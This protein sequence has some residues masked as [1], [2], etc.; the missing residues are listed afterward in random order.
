M[1][2]DERKKL[3]VKIVP[4]ELIDPNPLQPRSNLGDLGELIDSIKEKGVLEPIIVR[5][6]EERFEIISG[7]RRFRASIDAGLKEIPCI[8]VDVTDNEALEIALI[9]N[10]QRKDLTPFEESYGLKLL[11]ELYGYS[12]KEIAEKIGKSRSSIT[13]SIS[14]SKI[15][16]DVAEKCKELSIPS[17]TILVEIARL[18]NKEKMLEALEKFTSGI[19]NRDGIRKI[20]REKKEKK[21][22]FKFKGENF[23]LK[24][25]FRKQNVT[26]EELKEAIKSVLKKL[27]P[28]D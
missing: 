4:L 3:S 10:L 7:E 26:K 6:K 1:P 12:H 18:K 27:E 17:K 15:P 8:E 5:R 16:S 25:T 23:I 22:F 9:E 14:I 11:S 2:T 24:I 19:L 20:K 13:E 21:F 28:E